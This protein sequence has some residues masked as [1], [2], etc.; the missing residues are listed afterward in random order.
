MYASIEGAVRVLAAL[1]ERSI[2]LGHNTG[3][4]LP[5]ELTPLPGMRRLSA[6]AW[7]ENHDPFE[8]ARSFRVCATTTPNI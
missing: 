4:P 3:Q 5:T 1:G 6:R 2:Y 7:R 8:Y